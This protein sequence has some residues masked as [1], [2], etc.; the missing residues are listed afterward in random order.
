MAKKKKGGKKASAVVQKAVTAEPPTPLTVPI[1]GV[2]VADVVQKAATTK[3]PTGS[4]EEVHIAFYSTNWLL[5]QQKFSF[6]TIEI[7]IGGRGADDRCSFSTGEARKD[8]NSSE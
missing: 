4:I 3:P 6:V 1:E 5:R 8:G 2:K 7:L